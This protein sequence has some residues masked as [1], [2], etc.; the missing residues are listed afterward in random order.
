MLLLD[1]ILE[2]NLPVTVL[3]LL[4]LLLR[5]LLELV[6]ELPA[7]VHISIQGRS[8]VRGVV[9]KGLVLTQLEVIHQRLNKYD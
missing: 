1:L 2:A 7:V 3:K 6:G 4:L 5:K 8:L 9:Q